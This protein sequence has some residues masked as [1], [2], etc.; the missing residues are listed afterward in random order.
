MSAEVIKE[1]LMSLGVK[2][3]EAGMKRFND[4]LATGA[5]KAAAFATGIQAA[6]GAIYAGMWKIA[7]NS[8]E[9][10]NTSEALGLTVAR[11]K[12]LNF[13]ASLTG[14][15]ADALKSSMQG[16]QQSMA[17]ALIGG[18]GLATFAR[19]GVR[20]KDANG[21]LRDT[22]EVLM[23]VGQKIK[24]MDRPKAEM[25]MGQLGIDR[26][27]YK[28]LV[29]DISG[30]TEAYR[31]MYAAT[32]VDAQKAAEQSRDF[33]KEVKFL[34][35][36]LGM[37]AESVN[38]ALISK[39]G[40][41]ITAMRRTFVENFG[42]ITQALQSFLGLILR[43][44]GFIGAMFTR[45]IKWTSGL[46]DWFSK[47]DKSTQA[48]ALGV[49]GFA[50]AWRYLNLSFLMTPLGA[51]IALGV[52][53]AGL[54]DDFQTWQEGGESLID[55]GSTVGATI[56]ILTG[57]VA[58]LAAGFVLLPPIIAAVTSAWGACVIAVEGVTA[59]I[60]IMSAAAAA[61]PLGAFLLAAAL[62]AS[63]IIANWEKVK[64]W[65]NAFVDWFSDKFAPVRELLKSVGNAIG[66]VIGGGG[67]DTSGR[68]PMLGP[69]PAFAVAAAG[70]AG[71]G[72]TDLTANT[73]IYIDGAGDPESVGRAVGGQQSRVNA[74]LVRNT[75]GAAR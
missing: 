50:A 29:Q 48:L 53:I 35:A 46:V 75:R 49:V 23:E 4:G 54:I 58:T 43:V 59:A 72:G 16:L 42:K 22:S 47:L 7:E 65:F 61:N 34:K 28:M 57:V 11:L 8:A 3:D 14:S 70:A 15:S 13:V 52:T 37:L 64:E 44:A 18:G 66:A 2:V 1:F 32:G 68:A 41:N 19:L 71:A 39:F 73:N 30:V 38:I 12:E 24:K 17:G 74:D 51:L 10:L 25:F 27:L 33:V 6:A 55:W 21:H 56:G 20:I 40:P 62:A 9:L 67:G 63:L 5:T 60:G 69:S 45:I 31:E 36:V 26:S